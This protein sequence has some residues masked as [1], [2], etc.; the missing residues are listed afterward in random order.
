MSRARSL[1]LHYSIKTAADHVSRQIYEN[2]ISGGGRGDGKTEKR[3]GRVQNRGWRMDGGGRDPG[4]ASVCAGGGALPNE[5]PPGGDKRA[6]D[7]LGAGASAVEGTTKAVKLDANPV[8]V[9]S[10]AVEVPRTREQ[11]DAPSHSAAANPAP[12]VIP[13]LPRDLLEQR[14][15]PTRKDA[16]SG[17]GMTG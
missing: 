17:C 9:R 13:C 2:V 3:G 15:R 8:E 1:H 11:P 6:T 10:D 4:T 12:I 14:H 16:P 7:R 5:R